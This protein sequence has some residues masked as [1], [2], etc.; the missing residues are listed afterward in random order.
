VGRGGRLAVGAEVSADGLF[1]RVHHLIVIH[2][3]G[4]GHTTTAQWVGR[5][6]AADSL[7]NPILECRRR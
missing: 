7:N 4:L 2:W 3:S 6:V 1:L 5:E